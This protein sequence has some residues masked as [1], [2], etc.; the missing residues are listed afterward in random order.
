VVSFFVIF[1][2]LQNIVD[3][4]QRFNKTLHHA[5]DG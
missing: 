2:L 5:A 4:T 1:Y 3:A